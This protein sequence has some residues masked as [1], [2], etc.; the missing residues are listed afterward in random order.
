MRYVTGEFEVFHRS[1]VIYVRTRQYPDTMTFSHPS[2]G[3][4]IPPTQ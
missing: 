1:E 3:E 2:G 4:A